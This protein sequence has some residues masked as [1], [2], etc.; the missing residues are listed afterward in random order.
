MEFL[1]RFRVGFN[2]WFYYLIGV[3]LVVLG[4]GIIGQLPLLM[5]L[6]QSIEK[7]NLGTDALKKFEE[8]TDFSLVNISPNLGFLLMVLIFVG[9]MAG[10]Y[11]A[12][13][14]QKKRLIDITTSR[15]NFDYKRFFYGFGIWIVLT[16]IIEIIAYAIEPENY[17]FS[18]NAGD[19][20]FLFLITVLLLPVQTTFEELFFRGYLNQSFFAASKIPIVGIV[21][22][23]LLFSIVHSANPEIDKFG[24]FPMQLYYIGAGLFL[25]LVAYFDDG[26]EL[27]IGIHTATNVYGALCIKYEGSVL[28]TNALWS[29]KNINVYYMVFAFYISAII[30]FYLAA[31]KYNWQLNYSKLWKKDL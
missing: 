5:V 27:S 7:H 16:V 4:Y 14:I 24:F 25:A 19:F 29:M 20:V 23:T 3:V 26:L 22:T 13:R 11:F 1:R 30:F 9:A 12:C 21:V 17:Q 28:Q 18:F 8:T 2:D 6:Y 10:L 15:V 31:K